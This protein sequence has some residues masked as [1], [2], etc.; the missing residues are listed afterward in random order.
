MS[1][2]R[3]D[4]QILKNSSFTAR[5][6]TAPEIV[7]S[8][9]VCSLNNLSEDVTAEVSVLD[10]GAQFLHHQILGDLNGR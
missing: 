4:Q 9:S 8:R 1:E 5:R 7:H 6:G 3:E 2:P 10:D